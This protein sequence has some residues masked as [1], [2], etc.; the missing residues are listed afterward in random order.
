MG[1]TLSWV[2]EKLE[3]RPLSKTMGW[4]VPVLPCNILQ[5]EEGNELW[6]SSLKLMN[7]FPKLFTVIR[8][9][10]PFTIVTVVDVLSVE[11]FYW[12][13][14]KLECFT[15]PNKPLFGIWWTWS[16]ICT[17]CWGHPFF[18]YS[19]LPR[20]KVSCFRGSVLLQLYCSWYCFW[21]NEQFIGIHL[22]FEK[23]L[24]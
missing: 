2:N 3:V 14:E 1:V 18:C 15:C 19:Y 11:P 4:H 9:C 8:M 10:Y 24:A 20:M 13:K 12:W 21:T 16:V 17:S 23:L 7:P 22:L 6:A 5:L